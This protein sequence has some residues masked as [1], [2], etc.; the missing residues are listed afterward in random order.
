MPLLTIN[1]V[2]AGT[3]HSSGPSKTGHFWYTVSGDDGSHSSYGF[4]PDEPHEGYPFAPGQVYTNDDTAYDPTARYYTR[5]V[6]ITQTQFD[7]LQAFGEDPASFGF[8]LY[9]SGLGN[10]CVDFV[11]RALDL[12]GI[13]PDDSMLKGFQGTTWPTWNKRFLEQVLD[14]FEARGGGIALPDSESSIDTLDSEGRVISSVGTDEWGE[15]YEASYAYSSDGNTVVA[16]FTYDNNEVREKT[17]SIDPADDTGSVQV[18]YYYDGA[19]LSTSLSTT[20]TDGTEIETQDWT[21]DGVADSTQ[22]TTFGPDDSYTVSWNSSNGSHGYTAY[23]ANGDYHQEYHWVDSDIQSDI[24]DI[25]VDGSGHIHRQYVDGSYITADYFA[26]GSTHSEAHWSNGYYSI[27]DNYADGSSRNETHWGTAYAIY[28]HDSEGNML[29]SEDMDSL[30]RLSI[31]QMLPDGSTRTEWTWNAW[32]GF[33]LWAQDGSS[34]SE[35]YYL[36]ASAVRDTAADG[37]YTEAT[38]DDQGRLTNVLF[39]EADGSWWKQ[40]QRSYGAGGEFTDAWTTTEDH[41]FTFVV[42][43]DT[44]ASVQLG[45]NPIYTATLSDDSALPTW[46]SFDPGTR[47]FSGAP[48]NGEV[49][50]LDVKVTATDGATTSVAHVFALGVNNTN[51]APVADVPIEDQA[52]QEG[53]AFVFAVPEGAFVDVDGGDSLSYSVFLADGSALPEWLSFDSETRTFSG[54]PPESAAGE[55]GI[56]VTAT[57][58]YGESSFDDFTLSVTSGVQGMAG[59]SAAQSDAAPAASPGL[60]SWALTNA[61]LQAHLAANDES[62][63]GGDLGYWNGR[64]R[65]I[66]GISLNAFQQGLGSASFGADSQTLRPFTGLEEGLGRLGQVG[67]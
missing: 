54:M 52:A 63:D 17:Y 14:D 24:S 1:I 46:L 64:N 55:F 50:T 29:Y 65:G 30:G 40:Y 11:W 56:R 18:K 34:H 9:Y 60:S 21:G 62:A 33:T 41:A 44:F 51:D 2:R 4:A 66:N 28:L 13:V 61:L 45:E 7:A 39:V 27:L 6:E 8:S 36:Y 31:W 43:E 37:S 59:T 10:S 38:S 48:T 5:T 35:S 32:H 47:S 67:A 49:G 16:T 22:T 3:Q 20:A 53:E 23:A 58:S 42:P 57:D 12:G 19:L 26:D 25:D 15:A